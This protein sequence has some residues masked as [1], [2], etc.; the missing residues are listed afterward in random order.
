VPILEFEARGEA[1]GTAVEKTAF[2]TMDSASSDEGI[3]GRREID[4]A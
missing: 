4:E 1:R 3:D 2:G